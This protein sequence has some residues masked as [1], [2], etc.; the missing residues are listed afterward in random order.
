MAVSLVAAGCG[1]SPGAKRAAPAATVGAIDIS[2]A[3]VQEQLE[4]DL[5]VEKFVSKLQGGTAADI[6]KITRS[7]Q[8]Q[9]TSTIPT[10]K[11]AASLTKLMRIAALESALEARGAKVS[12]KDRK[13]ARSGVESDLTSQ[14]VDLKKLPKAFLDQQVEG[15]ALQVALARTVKV[16]TA[17][18]K[19]AY[20]KQAASF[21]QICVS[22]IFVKD[23]AAANAALA[24]VKA[25]EDFGKV[26]QEVT[27]DPTTA[28]AKGVIPC[29]DPATLAGQIDS[30]LSTAL[31]GDL[32][33]PTELL[34]AGGWVVSTI[35]KRE[36]TPLAQVKTQLEQ[37]IQAA[38]LPDL[39]EA[40]L[41]HV[42]VDPRYGTWDEKKAAVVPPGT[43]T[44]SK[45]KTTT[46]TA[47]N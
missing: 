14:G 1:S 43:K 31:V 11:A 13:E 21:E 9:G 34:S 15:G 37:Q 18:L 28:E 45:K 4:I 47:G 30:G 24:R 41:K 6:A 42:T 36:A 26:S 2:R 35:T 3:Q 10:D 12:A 22:L 44:T 25:G 8:G 7:Y 32:L 46:T 33:G 20:K 5:A 23:E 19:A 40:Q 38:K 27:V 16:S 17:Q 29:G 39:Y